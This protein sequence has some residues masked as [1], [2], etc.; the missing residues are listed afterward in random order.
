MAFGQGGP[1]IDLRG[2]PT[3]LE[4]IGEGVAALV[5]ALSTDP[6]DKIRAALIENPE[7]GRQAA[8]AWREWNSQ[9]ESTDRPGGFANM[10]LPTMPGNGL[11]PPEVMEEMSLMF[12]PT[13]EEEVNRA[14]GKILTP[15][16]E[17]AARARP[18]QVATAFGREVS[19]TE[20]AGAAATALRTGRTQ[21]ELGGRQAGRQ[22]DVLGATER[23]G[24]TPE[25]EGELIAANATLEMATLQFKAAG[26]EMDQQGLDDFA[27]MYAN[28]NPQDKQI[29]TAGLAGPRGALFGQALLNREGFDRSIALA[30]HQARLANAKTP[31]EVLES[32]FELKTKIRGERDRLRKLLDEAPTDQVPG[33][34]EDINDLADDLLRVDPSA[35]ATIALGDP[36]WVGTDPE[37]AKYGMKSYLQ[38]LDGADKMEVN[39]HMFAQRGMDETSLRQLRQSYTDSTGAVNEIMLQATIER[40]NQIKSGLDTQGRKTAAEQAWMAYMQDPNAVVRTQNQPEKT[41]D[42]LAT[43]LSQAIASG[44]SP[45]EIANLTAEVQKQRQ[46]EFILQRPGVQSDTRIT[47]QTPSGPTPQARPSPKTT[48]STPPPAPAV[49][50]QEVDSARVLIRGSATPEEDLTNAGFGPDEIKIILGR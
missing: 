40:A 41:S 14:M 22:L 43:K 23:A 33:L 11:I 13:R 2:S 45:L 17:A 1:V 7:M 35:V 37:R 16:E 34:I 36:G 26:L 25:K 10:Q 27:R 9:R 4:G 48:S 8:Q 39:A 3:G 12:P 31:Q 42:A 20:E 5:G 44:A 19:P 15:E 28:A 21:A 32:Q 29:M 30:N 47:T 49:T 46:F 6:K 38:T 50:Q 18:T 24:F